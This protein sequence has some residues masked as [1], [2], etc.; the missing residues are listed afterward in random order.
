MQ[1]TNERSDCAHA[2]FE[3]LLDA[4]LEHLKVEQKSGNSTSAYTGNLK[5]ADSFLQQQFSL[6]LFDSTVRDIVLPHINRFLNAL[7]DKG[8]SDKTKNSYIAALRSYFGFLR[9]SEYL[10]QDPTHRL[11]RLKI[12]QDVTK[13]SERFYSLDE[14]SSMLDY[15]KNS[16]R[17][18]NKERDSA[19]IALILASGLRASEACSL[20]M[21]ALSSI[22][23]HGYVIC[24]RKGGSVC[25][26]AVAQFAI[27]YLQAYLRTMPC[28]PAPNEPL[29]HSQKGG[30]LTRNALWWSLAQKQKDIHLKTGVHILR[31]NF[32]TAIKN[33]Q[34]ISLAADL[35][36]HSSPRVTGTYIHDFDQKRDAVNNTVYADLFKG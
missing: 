6:S 28:T 4:Y 25:K 21:E 17:R 2:I 8:C 7:D 5:R 12:V 15:F 33:D 26:V 23:E 14:V 11:S 27:P 29:F 32:L 36:G 24:K 3:S 20:N 16:A 34:S 35:A 18:K 22:I 19:I 10:K 9:A 1:T 31:H 13:Q 30:R